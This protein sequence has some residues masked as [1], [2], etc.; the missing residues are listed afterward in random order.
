VRP[1]FDYDASKY[2]VT[3]VDLPVSSH[4]THAS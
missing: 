4:I 2:M 3:A 1:D